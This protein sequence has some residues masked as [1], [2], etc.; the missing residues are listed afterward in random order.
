[1]D[2]EPTPTDTAPTEPV[3][4]ESTPSPDVTASPTP[5]PTP[6]DAPLVESPVSCGLTTETACHVYVPDGVVDF[7]G[8]S[9]VLVV[10][11]LA[12]ILAAQLRRP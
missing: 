7:G 10:L 11:M 3:P 6:S 8:A 1:M 2:P 9:A 5:T 12:A 4:T